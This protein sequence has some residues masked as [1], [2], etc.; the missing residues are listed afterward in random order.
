MSSAAIQNSI[1]KPTRIGNK[2]K[3]DL[4][5][6]F[7][8]DI[9]LIVNPA[10]PKAAMEKVGTGRKYCIF[11]HIKMIKRILRPIDHLPKRVLGIRWSFT[12]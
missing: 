12:G 2:F 4:S 9:K 3:T 7:K 1:N 10:N 8:V 5:L 6:F 11:I